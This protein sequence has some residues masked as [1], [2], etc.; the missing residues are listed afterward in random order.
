MLVRTEARSGAEW[1]FLS[2]PHLPVGR[3]GAPSSC[4]A[5]LKEHPPRS[6]PRLGSLEG[7][8]QIIA[9]LATTIIIAISRS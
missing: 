8:G 1:A 3:H 6:T 4:T 9:A 7:K 2:W 5:A